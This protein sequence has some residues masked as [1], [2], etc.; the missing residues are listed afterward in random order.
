MQ[1]AHN[2]HEIVEQDETMDIIKL[3]LDSETVIRHISLWIIEALYAL[4]EYTG[5]FPL[6]QRILVHL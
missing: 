2:T 5:N 4:G 6:S 3:G 1:S